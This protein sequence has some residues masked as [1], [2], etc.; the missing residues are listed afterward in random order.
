MVAA[1]RCCTAAAGP[2]PTLPGRY[3]PKIAELLTIT[4]LYIVF[5][6][7]DDEAEAVA[8]F[9]TLREQ[10]KQPLET[11]AVKIVGSDSSVL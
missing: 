5:D 8:S 7:F 10:L 9:Y 1:L 6:I 2:T 3:S 4:K 11:H